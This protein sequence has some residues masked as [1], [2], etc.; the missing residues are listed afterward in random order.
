MM[1][2][3]TRSTLLAC[4]CGGGVLWPSLMH[5]S[6]FC[7]FL[8]FILL[9]RGDLFAEPIRRDEVWSAAYF[10][11]ITRPT[12]FA[13]IRHRILAGEAA[14][15]TAGGLGAI[16]EG[17]AVIEDFVSL[18][19]ALDL[20]FD[21]AMKF[22]PPQPRGTARGIHEIARALKARARSALRAAHKRA[23]AELQCLLGGGAAPGT[24]FEAGNATGD[25]SAG[26]GTP[27]A[28]LLDE[29]LQCDRCD[30]WHELPPSL[31]P[32]KV[33]RRFTMAAI[34]FSYCVFLFHVLA[35]FASAL[36]VFTDSTRACPFPL[37]VR[38]LKRLPQ[39]FCHLDPICQPC[40]APAG[41]VRVAPG[42]AALVGERV[43]GGAI[44]GRRGLQR[45]PRRAYQRK[46]RGPVGDL[47]VPFDD[48][49]GNSGRD[50]HGGP[51]S[52]NTKIG[53]SSEAQGA[54][55]STGGM[56]TAANLCARL[57]NYAGLL[58]PD[59]GGALLPDLLAC[60]RRHVPA[61]LTSALPPEST[62]TATAAER[63]SEALHARVS[64]S[65]GPLRGRYAGLNFNKAL[66]I[67]K[68]WVD[69]ILD[70]RKTWEIRGSGVSFRGRIAL[71]ESGHKPPIMVGFADLVDCFP[72]PSS[73]LACP[74]VVACHQIPAAAAVDACARY[75]GNQHAWVLANATR[76]A[77]PV[78]YAHPSGAVKWILNRAP[79]AA[80]DAMYGALAPGC[81]A[82]VGPCAPE[83]TRARAVLASAVGTIAPPAPTAPWQALRPAAAKLSS[84]S[85]RTLDEAGARALFAFAAANGGYSK[86][87]EG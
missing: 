19:D 84:S 78:P 85:L 16:A 70:G 29:W 59:V 52:S 71:I 39:W 40:A 69:L 53:G 47:V 51:P 83:A 4:C 86:K 61:L 27:E 79:R 25:S 9:L 63:V 30:A 12:D 45:A 65:S 60:A 14:G 56:M 73:V 42:G 15:N 66:P 37:Q 23:N 75:R 87:R 62:I 81:T 1:H 50:G 17:D 57:E 21:N 74:T 7:P 26:L 48:K 31:P 38:A 43:K 80:C 54:E 33:R 77:A 64:V 46:A 35:W 11:L 28:P 82:V 32:A 6:S 41:T 68:H 67:R 22:T 72:V 58:G 20:C 10:S 13:T 76:F 36:D 8:L 3:I 55:T 34:F 2:A 24:S 18:G 5:C 44:P 49:G